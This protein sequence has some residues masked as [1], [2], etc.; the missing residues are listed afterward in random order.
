MVWHCGKKGFYWWVAM[1]SLHGLSGWSV[2]AA[3]PKP[4]AK[5][6]AANGKASKAMQEVATAEY[7]ASDFKKAAEHFHTCFDVDPK[8]LDCL[9]NAARAEQRS[10]AL[11]K[12]EEDF[13]KFIELAAPEDQGRKRALVHLDEIKELRTRLTPEKDRPKAAEAV[14]VVAKAPEAVATAPTAPVETPPTWRKPAAWGVAGL[15]AVVAVIGVAFLVGAKGE[16]ADLD[17]KVGD[18]SGDSKVT[19]IDYATYSKSQNDIN[20]SLVTADVLV[21]VGLGLAA[22]G[23]YFALTA[24]AAT[25]TNVHVAPLPSGAILSWSGRF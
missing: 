8:N 19:T 22:A 20:S 17:K 23:T 14:A 3:E 15:G 13:K 12:A 5:E 4:V 18:T 24:P 2:S 1:V 7:K 16:Q 21:G 9:F 11:D 6:D 10:F 25:G